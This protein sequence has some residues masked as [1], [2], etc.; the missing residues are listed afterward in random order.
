METK[1][2]RLASVSTTKKDPVSNTLPNE[3][4]SLILA[5]LDPGSDRETIKF[6]SLVARCWKDAAQA[7]LFSRVDVDN[8]QECVFW[9]QKFTDFPHLARHVKHLWLSD[10]EEDSA[11]G[12]YLRDPAGKILVSSLPCVLRLELTEVTQWGPVEMELIKGFGSTVRHLTLEGIPQMDPVKDLLELVYAFPM[13]EVLD[14]GGLGPDYKEEEL[15]Q[16]RARGLEM[17]SVLPADGKPRKLRELFLFDVGFSLDHLLWLSGPAFNL[18][19]L[20]NLTLYWDPFHSLESYEFNVL[21]DFIRL[22]GGNVTNLTFELLGAQTEYHSIRWPGE[23]LAEPGDLVIEHLIT[24][25]ILRNFTA[26]ETLTFTPF[27]DPDNPVDSCN[28][29]IY[30]SNAE[31]L[32]QAMSGTASHLKKVVFKGRFLKNTPQLCGAVGITSYL[33]EKLLSS[34]QAFPSLQDVEIHLTVHPFTYRDIRLPTWNEFAESILTTSLM[35]TLYTRRV[36]LVLIDH[37]EEERLPTP[38]EGGFLQLDSDQVSAIES[39]KNCQ[40]IRVNVSLESLL[41]RRAAEE[42][43]ESDGEEQGDD[44][45]EAQSDGEDP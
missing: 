26:L 9:S 31:H 38:N 45:E 43:D 20:R 25:P 7:R 17:R 11:N 10:D 18:S 36:K 12:P 37:E 30:V 19:G 8:N 35:R 23:R 32:L 15:D 27:E 42:E 5:F 22:V 14:L 6:I 13:I 29:P 16:I 44:G 1:K 28:H 3:I 34:N 24:S 33:F 41:A 40:V 39:M 21:D 2:P 4:V